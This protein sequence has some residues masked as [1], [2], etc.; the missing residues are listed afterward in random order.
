MVLKRAKCG[1][2][3][4]KIAIFAINRKNRPAGGGSAPFVT[5]LSSNGMF[6]TGPKL[7]NFCAK[8]F[9][10]VHAPSLLAKPWLCFWLHSLQQTYFSSDYTG[11]MQNELINAAGLICLF[12]QR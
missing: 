4:V 7:D 11:H 9:L 6:S 5:R 10:L 2:N 1:L 3:G 12:F 8:T